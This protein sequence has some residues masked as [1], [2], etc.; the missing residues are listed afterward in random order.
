VAR[1]RER[2]AMRGACRAPCRW[3]IGESA[4]GREVFRSALEDLLQLALR[5]VELLQFDERAAKRHARGQICGMDVEAG[6]ADVN[7]F[8]KHRGPPELFGELR[9]RD[10]RRVLLDPSSQIE[11]RVFRPGGYVPGRCLQSPGS[12]CRPIGDGG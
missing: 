10:R 2:R 5:L 6:A 1:Q 4:N 3:N 9:K 7:R 8:L 11:P 12:S